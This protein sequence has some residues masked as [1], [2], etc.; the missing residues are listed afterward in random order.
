MGVGGYGSMGVGEYGS[1]GSMG[2]W[3]WG[4]GRVE[5]RG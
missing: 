1:G 3:E 5:E 2:V 4:S